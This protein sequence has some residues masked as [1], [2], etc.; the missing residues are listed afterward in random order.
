MTTTRSRTSLPLFR[1]FPGLATLIP[2]RTLGT[3]P[4]RVERLAGLERHFGRTGLYIKRDDLSAR[5]YGGNKVR[6]LEFILAD[7]VEKNISTVATSGAAGSNHALATAIYGRMLGLSVD[8]MLF[9][10][11]ASDEVRAN[12]LA[13]FHAGARLHHSESYEEHCRRMEDFIR[14]AE[15]QGHSLYCIPPGGSCALGALGYVNAAFELKEQ[16][17]R[18]EL[19]EPDE[20]FVAYGTMGTA[21][22]LAL[23]LQAAGLKSR[24]RAVRVVPDTVANDEKYRELFE[25]TCKLLAECEPALAR[26]AF[27]HAV[28]R[29][30]DSFYGPGYGQTTPAGE[31]AMELFYRSEGLVLDQTYT[32]KTAAAFLEA[33]RQAPADRKLLFW[34]TKNSRPLPPESRRIDYRLLPAEFHRYFESA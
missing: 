20:I 31:E 15:Q 8:L 2:Y 21:A 12:L 19:P 34:L 26:A 27:D 6:K 13:G 29:A 14:T 1:A 22:G 3:L 18:G 25:S 9:A 11:A 4:T 16:V 23:G 30:D 32:A 10:Q 28:L 17:E 7:V 24:V 33:V 5:P